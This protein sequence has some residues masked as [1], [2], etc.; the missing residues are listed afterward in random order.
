MN[1][2]SY[3]ADITL[4]DEQL[5]TLQ[6]IAEQRNCTI[7]ES[8]QHILDGVLIELGGLMKKQGIK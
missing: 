6:F 1:E 2:F 3:T 4:T 8:I 5:K 7:Q